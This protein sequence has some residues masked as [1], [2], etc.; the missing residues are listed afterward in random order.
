MNIIKSTFNR[1]KTMITKPIAEMTTPELLKPMLLPSETEV[2]RQKLVVKARRFHE[3]EEA[4][5][6]DARLKDFLSEDDFSLNFVATINDA[7]TE[8]LEIEDTKVLSEKGVEQVDQQEWWNEFW[9]GNRLDV[10]QADIHETT[11]TESEYFGIIDFDNENN[12]ARLTP[13]QRYIA[14]ERGGDDQGVMMV[15]PGDNYNRK[16]LYA[17]KRWQETIDGKL[18]DHIN[19]YAPGE[20]IEYKRGN[21]TWQEIARTKLV[22]PSTGESLGIPV[23]HFKTPKLRPEAQRAWPVQRLLNKLV[24]DLVMESDQNAFRI[25][26]FFG[27]EPKDKDGN[28]IKINVGSWVGAPGAKAG[29]A[30]ASPVEP[31]DLTSQSATIDAFTLRMVMLTSTPASRFQLGKQV[32][33]EGT[34]KQQEAPLIKKCERRSGVLATAW[35]DAFTLA[36]RWHNAFADPARTDYVA[37]DESAR[38]EVEWEPFYAESQADLQVEAQTDMLKVNLV[39]AKYSAGFI[40]KKQGALELGYDETKFEEMMKN[41]D[42]ENEKNQDAA[43]RLFNGGGALNG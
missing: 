2:K 17:L 23:V 35:Q 31:V 37:L 43:A 10:H 9:R 14:A 1:I 42:A 33:A 22:N 5:K 20:L 26:L 7:V 6:L 4:A 18:Q 15:Y 11:I 24:T 32:A 39:S 38:F 40:D 3:G 29:D 21:A 28:P 12:R 36:R 34:L 19:L 8:R 13:H 30:T 25:W 16:P 41:R 27:W